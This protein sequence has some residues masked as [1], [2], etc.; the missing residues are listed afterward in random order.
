MDL[1]PISSGWRWI[2]HRLD[3][4][5]WSHASR[6]IHLPPLLLPLSYEF[7]AVR[8]SSCRPFIFVESRFPRRGTGDGGDLWNEKCSYWLYEILF[9]L[10]TC[11]LRCCFSSHLFDAF[12]SARDFVPFLYLFRHLCLICLLMDTANA[13]TKSEENVNI[14]F[15]N[16]V[17]CPWVCYQLGDQFI[18]V[19]T[20]SYYQLN[21]PRR[22]VLTNFDTSSYNFIVI[23]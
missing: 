2:L 17:F 15:C 8:C 11:S 5:N 22:L 10:R 7:P 18:G 14:Y 4:G 23:Y 1:A 16:I 21:V 3:S 19:C 13:A 20:P 9:V 6:W 12:R